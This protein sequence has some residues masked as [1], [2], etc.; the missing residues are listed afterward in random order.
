MDDITAVIVRR[1]PL[2]TEQN[3]VM[4][5]API[6]RSALKSEHF[7]LTVA[8]KPEGIWYACGDEWIKFCKQAWEERV[9]P[10]VYE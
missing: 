10:Y 8:K 4:W 1:N 3:I 2:K 6:S 5:R 9:T 7:N